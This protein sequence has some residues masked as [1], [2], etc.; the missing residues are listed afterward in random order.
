MFKIDRTTRGDRL[1]ADTVLTPSD[2]QSIAKKLGPPLRARKIGYVAARR[3]EKSGTVETRWNGKET[4]NT[5]NPG[6]WI[7]TNLSRQLEPLRDD[8]GHMNVYVI[9]AERFPQL[10][11]PAEGKSPHGAVYRAMGVVSVLPVP[12]GLDIAAP[13]GER[14]TAPAGYLLCNGEEVYGANRE[15]FEATY[16]FIKT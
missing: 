5:A 8:E 13:W 14:Q 11:E 9:A 4:T 15:A 6:D 10:Y 1:E 2:F 3:E 12:G 16:E 7:A